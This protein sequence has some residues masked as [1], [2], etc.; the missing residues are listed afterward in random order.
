MAGNNQ[1]LPYLSLLVCAFF[2]D[3]AFIR[4]QTAKPGE[5]M[6]SVQ[7]Q[8]SEVV[9]Q[10]NRFQIPF[11]QQNRNILLIE[12]KE[13]EQLPVRSI[14]E[15]LAYVPGIDLRQRGPWGGQADLNIDGGTFEQTMVLLNGVKISDPQTA[16]NTLN[17]P[18]PL[19]AVE[20][21]EV[22]RGPAARLYGINS[23]TG[24]INIVTRKPDKNFFEAGL[25]AGSSFR[26]RDEGDGVYNGQAVYAGGGFKKERSQ[27][28]IF[29]NYQRGNGYRYNTANDLLRFFYQGN[30]DLTSSERVN[31]Q[32]G[33][34]YNNFGANGFYAAPGDRESQE[35]IQTAFAS[36]E[37]NKQIDSNW[38]FTP[39]FSY[40]YNHDDYRY[41]RDDL[42]Q[43]RNLH[44]THVLS[45]EL[46]SAYHSK[47]GS[48]GLGVELR[49]EL[50]RSTNL[51]NH[52]RD[53]V[54]VYT[55]YQ[56]RE[57]NR[58][59]LRLGTYLNYNSDFGWKLYPGFDAG[60]RL[61]GDW[62]AFINSGTG[63]RVPSFTDLY[64]VSPGNIGNPSLFSEYAWYAEGGIKYQKERLNLHAS[65]FFRQ[66]DDY[67][68]WTRESVDEAWYPENF[69]QNRTH[70]LS[71]HSKYRFSSRY[72]N[73]KGYASLGYTLLSPSF[74]QPSERRLSRYAIENLRHQLIAG[75]ALEVKSVTLSLTD[76]FIERINYRNYHLLDMRVNYR[77]KNFDL[78]AEGTNLLDVDY[79]EA[80]A[81]PLPGSWFTT[82]VHLR[83]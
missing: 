29:G 7:H 9:I 40:R 30:V 62:K 49:N 47:I 59:S 34:V 8:L 78:Y 67:I 10:E 32:A 53:N 4:A 17:L 51:G 43:F 1:L 76:R 57:I 18:I 28:L 66:I 35:L 5:S 37:Y 55:E 20:R 54:G 25:E 79:V 61:N 46:H 38:R 58:F 83:L 64:Y 27:H 82:G 69:L 77:F 48:F 45:S 33:Y 15:A 22:I 3:S 73:W 71:F 65:Y 21:I 52:N 6:D 60:Y 75:I 26:K 63:Q 39:R 24:A 19:A 13:I 56:L 44:N 36:I 42:R 11:K 12:R 50:V 81:V 68:D 14:Q 41:F 70:G 31:L 74:T 23:L 80:G 72:A 16:H 2:L